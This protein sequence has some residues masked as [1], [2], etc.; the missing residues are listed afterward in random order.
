M[1]F[2]KSEQ[3]LIFKPQKGLFVSFFVLRNIWSSTWSVIRI[4]S[5]QKK[6]KYSKY[7]EGIHYTEMVNEHEKTPLFYIF[8]LFYE[9]TRACL[10][11]PISSSFFPL[12]L[13]L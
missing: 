13:P 8:T 3:K 6:K 5:V 11:L 12:S 4:Y 10:F 2:D 1:F 7:D 9:Y